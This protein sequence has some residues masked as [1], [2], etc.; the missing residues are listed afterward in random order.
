MSESYDTKVSHV[1]I[2]CCICLCNSSSGKDA[3]YNIVA[4]AKDSVSAHVTT[5]RPDNFP[6]D[7]KEPWLV[8]FFAP[9]SLLF[10]V[11]LLKKG[12]LKAMYDIMQYNSTHF[13]LKLSYTK[14][15]VIY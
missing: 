5:L 2:F 3:L 11:C 6:R 8:D 14:P 1:N 12:T 7:E 15:I 9:V 4:F 13:K 10:F